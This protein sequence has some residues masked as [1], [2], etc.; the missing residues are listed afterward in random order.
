M[1]ICRRGFATYILLGFVL[2][3]PDKAFSALPTLTDLDTEKLKDLSQTFSAVTA[4]KPV[5]PAGSI[6]DVW[7]AS[8]GLVIG[9]VST[10]KIKDYMGGSS[11][12]LPYIMPA[13]VI[14]VPYGLAVEFG[15]LPP[16]AV[17]KASLELYGGDI[18][19]TFTDVIWQKTKYFDAAIRGGYSSARINYGQTVS[20]IPIKIDFNTAVT[21]FS[22]SVGKNFRLVEPYVTFGYFSQ[23]STLGYEGTATIFDQTISASSSVSA[24]TSHLLFNAGF[25]LKLL[26]LTWAFEYNDVGG[27]NG[28]AMKLAFEI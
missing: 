18:K 5:E 19:W 7:G 8:A 12:I 23:T 22:L 25:Q 28:F 17:S 27:V 11:T 10:Y 9:E 21:Q 24:E 16:I 14:N 4:F 15:G 1:K 3:I 13:I 20:G 6:G 2:L 26:I